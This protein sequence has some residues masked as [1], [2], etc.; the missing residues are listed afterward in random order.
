MSEVPQAESY[1]I[2]FTRT[3]IYEL[4]H[5]RVLPTPRRI[6]LIRLLYCAVR[7]HDDGAIRVGGLLARA[8][9]R[10]A[11]RERQGDVVSAP[12]EVVSLVDAVLHRTA[13]RIRITAH[14]FAGARE[15]EA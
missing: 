13:L 4:L 9:L 3:M 7:R 12:I 10:W 5:R 2:A 15:K 6:E 14:V 8:R 11:R 1:C